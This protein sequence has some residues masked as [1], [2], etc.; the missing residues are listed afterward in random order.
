MLQL[1]FKNLQHQSVVVDAVPTD[2]TIAQLRAL[3]QQRTGWSIARLVVQGRVLTDGQTLAA[4]GI[5]DRAVLIC[6]G[7][8]SKRTRTDPPVASPA[9][10]G[11]APAALA[12]AA[13]GRVRGLLARHPELL[14]LL[15]LPDS[16]AGE[17]AG[18]AAFNG[19][20]PDDDLQRVLAAACGLLLASTSAR[21]VVLA[22]L[23]AVPWELS[24]LN[25][26]MA[27][28]NQGLPVVPGHTLLAGLRWS[29][30]AEHR[31]AEFL[32]A[33]NGQ[34]PAAA[35]PRLLQRMFL[36]NSE[37]VSGTSACTLSL[38]KTFIEQGHVNDL[39]VAIEADNFAGPRFLAQCSVGVVG[40]HSVLRFL[41]LGYQH[42]PR[43]HIATRDVLTTALTAAAGR[44]QHAARLE[45]ETVRS[46]LR[47]LHGNPLAAS[48]EQPAVEAESDRNVTHLALIKASWVAAVS[49]GAV[50]LVRAT[51]SDAD[52][53]VEIRPAGLHNLGNTCFANAWLQGLYLAGSFRTALIRAPLSTAAD[54]PAVALALQRVLASLLLGPRRA[55]DATEFF[56][57]MPKWDCIEGWRSRAQQQD[58]AE[59]GQLLL[60][61]VERE[62]KGIPGAEGV[63]SNVFGGVVASTVKCQRCGSCSASR[64]H[65]EFFCLSIDLTH[66]EDALARARG[67]AKV[68]VEVLC[69]C[70]LLARHFID[71]KLEDRDGKPIY[72]CDGRCSSALVSATK[73]LVVVEAPRHMMISLKRF[74]FDGS[75]MK[76]TRRVGLSLWI[77]LP[78]EKTPSEAAPPTQDQ[79][80]EGRGHTQTDT[81]AVAPDQRSGCACESEL[82][83]SPDENRLSAWMYVLYAVVV[84]SGTSANSGHYYTYGRQVTHD[85][86]KTS[87]SSSSPIA[88]LA[89]SL[90]NHGRAI[91]SM[92]DTDRDGEAGRAHVAEAA[93]E[94]RQGL[95][96]VGFSAEQSSTDQGSPERSQSDC[97]LVRLASELQLLESF[98]AQ[99]HTASGHV[100]SAALQSAVNLLSQ[101]AEATQSS[102][103]PK[104]WLFNDATVSRVTRGFDALDG[105][106]ANGLETPYLLLYKRC[107]C[108]GHAEDDHLGVDQIPPTV[109][110]AVYSDELVSLLKSGLDAV[111]A[112]KRAVPKWSPPPPGGGAGGG[113]ARLPH[114]FGPAGGGAGAEHLPKWGV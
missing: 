103:P 7:T 4:A 90:W 63:V 34:L 83:T 74:S 38:A 73:R 6:I 56:K 33:C 24:A 58:S 111:P 42:S 91:A 48:V 15:G 16:L 72:R 39:V 80:S 21:P 9:V 107:D 77:W 108:D 70:Q 46:Y 28:Q 65:L 10:S 19:E 105:L 11:L 32:K 67:S 57:A 1:V 30:A 114:R 88:K 8:A 86:L 71:E 110:Y 49:S 89:A 104:W 98:A 47:R 101:Y 18:Q 22:L 94:L 13:G 25:T 20:L 109:R 51:V 95:D 27:L 66:S 106:G 44:G 82:N 29:E 17:Q 41:L 26:V 60:D 2:A 53:K 62:V 23:H 40:V 92:V 68:E 55:L 35:R 69:T 14:G 43:L 87:H 112:T 85:E 99:N 79:N 84:H 75:A 12:A 93:Q 3:A 64:E 81:E 31:R 76:V 5:A 54:R 100:V 78:H 96:A 97:I 113:A 61:R 102:S 36:G 50:Q 52:G 37:I 45:L 59:F